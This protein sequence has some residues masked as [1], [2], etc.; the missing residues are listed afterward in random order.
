MLLEE[1]LTGI[2]IFS[3]WKANANTDLVTNRR[4]ETRRAIVRARHKGANF[5][6]LA[7]SLSTMALKSGLSQIAACFDYRLFEKPPTGHYRCLG[8]PR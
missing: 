2:D 7:A 6:S 3:F 1:I 5:F 4:K 8:N